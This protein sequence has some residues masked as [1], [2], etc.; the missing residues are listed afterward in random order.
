MLNVPRCTR[1]A[2]YWDGYFASRAAPLG[3][4]PAHVV[5]AAFYSFAEGEAAR[6]IPSAN[7]QAVVSF[8]VLT[9]GY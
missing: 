6:H 7:S 9:V 1:V 3:R 8:S 5:H 4:V 2:A